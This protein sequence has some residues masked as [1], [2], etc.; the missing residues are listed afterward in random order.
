M[1]SAKQSELYVTL[2]S[3]ISV[4]SLRQNYPLEGHVCRPSVA[5]SERELHTKLEKSVIHTDKSETSKVIRQRRG[6]VR[7]AQ[8]GALRKIT[9]V[10]LVSTLTRRGRHV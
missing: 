1:L 4:P 5:H 6:C 8:R 3:F 2:L 10:T 9:V 7:S